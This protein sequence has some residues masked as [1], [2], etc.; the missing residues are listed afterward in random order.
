MHPDFAFDD[1]ESTCDLIASNVVQK[2][3]MFIDECYTVMMETD[4]KINTQ[5]L[6]VVVIYDHPSYM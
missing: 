5:G 3:E 2:E 1:E 4:N 6:I